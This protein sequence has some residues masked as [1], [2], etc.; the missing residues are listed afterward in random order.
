MRSHSAPVVC[1]AATR[2]WSIVVSGSKDGSA[3]LWD[4]NR[5][6][7]VRSIWHGHGPNHMVHLV[8]IHESTVGHE[9]LQCDVNL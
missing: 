6:T 8:A 7:Y 1:V 4:L 9:S 2:T 5:G 3:V